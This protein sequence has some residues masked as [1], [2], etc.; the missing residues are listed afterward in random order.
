M[1]V[2]NKY[3]VIIVTLSFVQYLCLGF[4]GIKN[5]SCGKLIYNSI[6]LDSIPNSGE[7]I[8]KI[9]NIYNVIGEPRAMAMINKQFCLDELILGEDDGGIWSFDPPILPDCNQVSD[10]SC[11]CV[12]GSSILSCGEFVK[13]TYTVINNKCLG[14]CSDSTTIKFENTSCSGTCEKVSCNIQPLENECDGQYIITGYS[15]NGP[16]TFEITNAEGTVFTGSGPDFIFTSGEGLIHAIVMDSEGCMPTCTYY[17]DPS[18]CDITFNESPDL[19]CL[20]NNAVIPEPT[21]TELVSYNYTCVN[22][23][24]DLIYSGNTGFISI[25]DLQECVTCDLIATCVNGCDM[26]QQYE[27][28]T[29]DIIQVKECL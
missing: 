18:E 20:G 1:N 27:V 13:V 3:A 15:P 10:G 16:V 14:D 25:T 29:K 22:E 21:T 11:D 26:M 2:I 8:E 6:L 17:A 24:Q 19:I 7:P 28:C 12:F 23:N 4:F 9:F 5:K